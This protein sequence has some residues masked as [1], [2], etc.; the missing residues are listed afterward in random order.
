[1]AMED[2]SA[3]PREPAWRVALRRVVRALFPEARELERRR[4]LQYIALLVLVIVIAIALTR[5]SGPGRSP[6][7]L[8]VHDGHATVSSVA[9]PTA[10][11]FSSLAVSSGRLRLLGGERYSTLVYDYETTLVDGR[12]AGTCDAAIVDPRTLTIG[13]VKRAN[14]GDPTLYGERVLPIIYFSR[15]LAPGQGDLLVRIARTDPAARDGYT[16]GPIVTTYSLCSDCQSAVIYG[17]G[18]LW[19]Y[20]PTPS[21]GPAVLL[22]ISPQS[23]AVVERWAMPTILRALLAVNSHGLWLSPSIESSGRGAALYLITPGSKSPQRVLIETGSGARWLLA[24]GNTASA[25]ID[26]G[27]GY[28]AVWTFTTGKRPVHGPRLSDFPMGA[29]LGTGGPTVAGNNKLGY[30]NVVMN[31]GTESVIETTPDGRR[32][33]TIATVRSPDS[34]DSYPPVS[35]VALGGSLFFLDPVTNPHQR[36]DLHRVT[37]H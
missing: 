12:V 13:Q 3:S 22:R 33:H 19:I 25:A 6:G 20:N 5:T 36:G 29:E 34:T 18:S 7:P 2:A 4:R 21:N 9:L 15:H 10:D 1:M 26:K 28:S 30:Y 8:G 35:S 24:S 23:G 11:G 16:L 32:E 17:D 14:C 31:N 37:P 27:D